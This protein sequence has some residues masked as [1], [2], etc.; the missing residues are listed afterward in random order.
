MSLDCL[1]RLE[2][3]RILF[4]PSVMLFF[5][6]D[7]EL[8]RECDHAVSGDDRELVRDLISCSS[9]WPPPDRIEA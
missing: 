8:E 6:P 2:V 5:V 4:V 3:L 1:S 7:L 9:N